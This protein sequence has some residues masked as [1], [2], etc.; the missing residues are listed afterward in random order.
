M[1]SEK[2]FKFLVICGLLSII[3]MILITIGV[4]AFLKD[5]Y[6]NEP[7]L[8]YEHLALILVCLNVAP[9]IWAVYEAVHF[10]SEVM[11][12]NDFKSS[13]TKTSKKLKIIFFVQ[14]G[15]TFASIFII[16]AIENIGPPAVFVFQMFVVFTSLT[17]ALF[18]STIHTGLTK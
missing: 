9:S 6:A 1:T 3:F 16:T 8:K 2:N 7:A 5:I 17:L 12:D 18:F 10:A 4:S 14:A 11:V 13:L 15:Y